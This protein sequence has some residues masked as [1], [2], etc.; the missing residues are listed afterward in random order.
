ME[1]KKEKGFLDK[2]L[3]KVDKKLEKESKKK[4]CC[5]DCDCG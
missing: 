1:E 5:G 2:L 4:P 3:G